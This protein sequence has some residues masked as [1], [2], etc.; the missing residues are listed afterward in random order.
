MITAGSGL[1]NEQLSLQT[2][3][4]S[5]NPMRTISPFPKPL[6]AS[7]AAAL[8]L[9][10]TTAGVFAAETQSDP[11]QIDDVQVT[12]QSINDRGAV[13]IATQVAFTNEYSA[14]ATR[15]VFLLEVNGAV[16]ARLDDVGTFAPGVLV[17]HRFPESQPGGEISVIA[18][19]A[20]FADGTKWQNSAVADV[21][22]AEPIVRGVAA[23]KY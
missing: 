11:I 9:A 8:F 10:G 6:A 20:T 12:S 16:V 7:V 18:A 23:D 17:R 5:E 1:Q 4:S 13:P 2:V 15:V 14:A 21:S 22:G 3:E 19:A